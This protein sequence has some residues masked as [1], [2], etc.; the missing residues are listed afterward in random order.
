MTKLCSIL[1]A[2]GFA[3]AAQA[4][5]LRYSSG[6]VHDDAGWAVTTNP[7]NGDIYVTGT[8]Y[9]GAAQLN[10][11]CLV[12]YNANGVFQWA[13]RFG[14]PGQNDEALDVAISPVNGEIY[15]TGYVRDTVTGIAAVATLHFTPNGALVGQH[16]FAG[17]MQ[18]DHIGQEIGF[19]MFG[20]VYVRGL[21]TNAGTGKDFLLIKYNPG[22]SPLW[23][24]F[25][26]GA[27]GDDISSAMEV[28]PNG[29]YIVGK[30]TNPADVDGIALRY[31]LGGVLANT[32]YVIGVAGGN[33]EINDIAV[34]PGGGDVL[35]TSTRSR[36][37]AASD[38]QITTMRWSGNFGA[39]MWVHNFNLFPG[40]SLDLAKKVKVSPIG[41]VV[42]GS[43]QNQNFLTD[44]VCYQLNPST[45][46]IVGL[47]VTNFP[48]EDLAVDLAVD[49]AGPIYVTGVDDAT[50]YP[51]YLTLRIDGG[52]ITWVSA[53]GNAGQD[54]P[55]ELTLNMNVMP[56][57]TGRSYDPASGFD[58]L[59]L[60]IDPATGM[61]L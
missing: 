43:S 53:Y 20:G 51:K 4:A 34:A 22:L 24:K 9:A 61:V 10:D 58:I 55:S 59:T 33:D 15:V 40:N 54:V 18:G 42:A 19:D 28:T 14:R 35:I 26:D 41:V 11:M 6:G 13:R 49:P 12:K 50:G 23:V 7:G 31:T 30:S 52:L 36:G 17:L 44:I 27:N 39:T 48:G 37:P 21:A 16:A 32:R 29:V 5:P 38:M 60:R 46:G 47:Q 1:L 8:A 57:V 2:I 3:L 25:W 56:V 45:G